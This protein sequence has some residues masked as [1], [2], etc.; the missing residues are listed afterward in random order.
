ML[1]LLKIDS[2][3]YPIIAIATRLLT[4][5]LAMLATQTGQVIGIFRLKTS[6]G[7]PKIIHT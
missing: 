6:E 4:V 5:M 2:K 3:T 7:A 1:S